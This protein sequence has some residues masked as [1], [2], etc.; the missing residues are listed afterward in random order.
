M[1]KIVYSKEAYKDLQKIKMYI[2]DNF[3][4][5]KSLEVI[6][7][8][9]ID[10]KRLENYPKAGAKLSEIIGFKTDYR[11]LFTEKNYVFYNLE[12]EKVNIIRIINEK[13][14]FVGKLF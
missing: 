4:N 13:Q 11:Y 8:I 3:G 6:K 12:N 5:K 9:M 14:N 10:I 7:K 2:S 1:F